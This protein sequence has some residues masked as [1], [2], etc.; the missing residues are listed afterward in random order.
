MLALCFW[1]DC[2]CH[3]VLQHRCNNYPAATAVSDRT[4]LA[5]IEYTMDGTIAVE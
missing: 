2:V 4:A 3:C 5:E 1:T